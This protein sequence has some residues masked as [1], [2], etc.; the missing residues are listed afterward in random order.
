MFM[1]M[2]T[3]YF[4]AGFV[5]TKVPFPLTPRF[6]L[7]LQRGVDIEELLVL[8]CLLPPSLQRRRGNASMLLLLL[9]LPHSHPLPAPS[10][11][12]SFPFPPPPR[13]TASQPTSPPWP[14]TFS[15]CLASAGCTS[16]SSTTRALATRP[17]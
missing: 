12:S 3:S 16:S 7:M 17:R 8:L 13:T 9:I 15:S 2:L 10:R 4:F 6:K 11:R 1:M 5:V 14:G